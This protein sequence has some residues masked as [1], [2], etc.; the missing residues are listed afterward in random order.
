LK[1]KVIYVISLMVVLSLIV[2]P[3]ANT[4]SAQTNP[5]TVILDGKKINFDV[6]PVLKNN[7]VMVPYRALLEAMGAKVYW[8]KESGTIRSTREDESVQF[9]LYSK[10]AYVNGKKVNLDTAPTIEK[11]RALVP[12]R[13]ISENFNGKV[14]WSNSQQKVTIDMDGQVANEEDLKIILNNK[15]LSL[16]PIVIDKQTYIPFEPFVNQMEENPIWIRNGNEILIEMVGASVVSYIGKTGARMNGE[17]IPTS[18]Y[19][20]EK[21]GEIYVPFRYVTDVLGGSFFVTKNEI[22]YNINHTDHKKDFL[23]VK[24]EQIIVPKN[25]PSASLNGERRLLVSD[26]P[27]NLT[28][29]NVPYDSITLWDDSVFE[30]KEEIE[31]R[32]HGWHLN[33][34]GDK[35]R[36]GITIEN[37]SATNDIKVDELEGIVRKSSSSWQNYD[38]GLPIAEAVLNENLS[39]INMTNPIIKAG[40]T[41]IIQ[42]MELNHKQLI[43]FLSDFSVKKNSGTGELDYVVRVVLTQSDIDLTKI[44]LSHIEMNRVK[45]HPRGIWSASQV[46]AEFP[47]YQVGSEEVAYSISNGKTDDLMTAETSLGNNRG[48]VRNPGHYGATY[49]VVIPLENYTGTTK[50]VRV[51]LSARGGSYNGA[52]K[53]LDEVYLVPNLQPATEVV[54]VI[55]YPVTKTSDVLELELMHSGGASLPIAIDLVTID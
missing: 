18:G 17:P 22:Y 48:A 54:H 26:N 53:V 50:T 46:K 16:K 8:N 15:E 41:E 39:P 45:S 34:L 1:K 37:K 33:S 19:P 9:T 25:V 44:K 47:V 20:V 10:V 43:G 36:L 7:R 52:I 13:F 35:I 51:R 30:D 24:Q 21:N 4:V 40:E 42:T 3:L 55:D 11:G 12:L 14:T 5:I 23:E 38:V 29:D 2:S 6:K 27:E 31:H 28:H 32:V 49:K